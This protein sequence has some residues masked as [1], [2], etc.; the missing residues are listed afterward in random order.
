MAKVTVI[1]NT[2]S[3]AS[4]KR[5][6]LLECALSVF[7]QY[8][9]SQATMDKVA[10]LAGSSKQTI[11]GMFGDKD[12]LFE[13]VFTELSARLLDHQSFVKKENASPEQHLTQIA[14]Q[15]F[16]V[17]ERE[18]YLSFFRLVIA[19]SGR[20]PNLAAAYVASVVEPSAK[21]LEQY[22]LTQ[23]G[24]K[25][26]DPKASRESIPRRSGQFYFGTGST[27]R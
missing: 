27:A 8:G 20:F 12:G 6:H 16:D 7:L 23:P 19:E 11:Y 1:A 22:L 13:A 26:K 15:F 9:Y 21:E 17:M 14:N 4:D 5:S 24:L 3:V 10:A 18:E 25:V 2:A